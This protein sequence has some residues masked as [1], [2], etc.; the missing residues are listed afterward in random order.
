[1]TSFSS[2]PAPSSSLDARSS[3]LGRC[4]N[5][6]HA[7][8]TIRKDVGQRP[9][10]EPSTLTFS[11]YVR[12]LAP[13][14]EPPGA[15]IFDQLIGRLRGALVHEMKKRGLWQAPPS[16]L[17]VY[18]G[19]SWSDGDLLE[20]L[21]YEAYLFVFVHRL[22]GLKRQM[23]LRPN[24]D[25]LV[26]LNLRHFLH[27]TQKRH[28][29]LGFRVYEVAHDA[30]HALVEA[31]RL[32][33]LEGEPK[34]RGSTVL[35]FA[36]WADA[37]QA[38]GVDLRQF[39]PRWCDELLPDLVTAWARG[40]TV[41]GFAE[42]LAGIRDD[43][44]EAFHFQ[45]LVESLKEEV[46]TRWQ[47][48]GRV[49]QGETALE[50]E[51]E[52]SF[53]LVRAVRPDSGF[54]ERQAFDVLLDCTAGRIDT[55][56]GNRKSR[57]YLHR[58][59]LYLR[60]WASEA[61]EDEEQWPSDKRLSEL[62]EIPR[63]RIR[64]LKSMVGRFVEACR[65]AQ[66]RAGFG[67]SSVIEVK[68]AAVSSA[69][70]LAA[71]REALR[72]ATGEAA[73]RVHRELAEAAARGADVG[74]GEV[75]LCRATRDEPLAWAVVDVHPKNRGLCRA[76]PVDDHP[77]AGSDDVVLPDGVTVVRGAGSVLV[78]SDAFEP[79]LR[80][81][82]LP[83]AALVE[84]RRRRDEFS[85]GARRVSW[86]ERQA[87]DDPEYRSWQTALGGAGARLDASARRAKVLTFSP[88]RRGVIRSLAS[89]AAF[90]AL[91]SLGLLF[92]VSELR[93]EIVE[94]TPSVIG[95][96]ETKEIRF[97]ETTRGMTLRIAAEKENVPIYLLLGRTQR[98]PS[99]RLRLL[100]PDGVEVWS[101]ELEHDPLDEYLLTLP[102]SLL[103]ETSYTLELWGNDGGDLV[104]IGEEEIRVEIR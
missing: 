64:D 95:S 4:G 93:R 46:R 90:F 29:P 15:E 3:S 97:G 68:G 12:F 63:A 96:S 57:D 66:K 51:D 30:V 38:D 55:T 82:V 39:S 92:Y 103:R 26:F 19:T 10:R 79:A 44:V 36:S 99:Y 25:G 33:V 2:P 88:R 8:M 94:P 76:A 98:Y 102:R 20:D 91:A 22:A 48:A 34:L 35:G 100:D 84:V 101:G 53:A 24:V 6:Y 85:V 77:L 80:V 50:E 61:E 75:F 81:A 71:R 40:D 7:W 60:S 56:G 17:G 9:E 65:E 70:S 86:R 69:A 41:A 47:M 104:R 58:L 52:G 78:R 54:E 1:M 59:W 49:E 16:Y 31:G 28:D 21:T 23:L 87:E 42:R 89:L 73:G 37:R 67:T 13:G 32:H 83:E 5:K 72:Q 18:G 45:D 27:E 43:G 74:P 14:G 62:L 11:D